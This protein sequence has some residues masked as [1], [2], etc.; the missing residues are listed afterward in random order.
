MAYCDVDD[1]SQEMQL[2][3]SIEG[4]P[5]QA[6]VEE[7]IE[8][9]SSD[10]DGIAQAAGYTVPIT[11]TSALRVMKRYCRL[12]TAAQV[13]SSGFVAM[14]NPT[15]FEYW[16]KECE[17]FKERLRDGDQQLPGLTPESDL[18]PVFDIAESPCRDPYLCPT[19]DED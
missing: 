19:D 6:D 3:F 14:T 10:L 12:C 15:R 1:V 11:G 16:D 2:T 4:Y 7:V 17:G 5:S 18:D 13:W 8:E 9:I